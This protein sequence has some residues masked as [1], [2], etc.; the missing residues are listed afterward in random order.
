MGAGNIN[1]KML[2][3]PSWDEKTKSSVHK[4][5]LVENTKSKVVQKKSQVAAPR[6][7]GHKVNLKPTNAPLRK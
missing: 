2:K 4:W 5:P 7:Q 3:N 1:G 6:K